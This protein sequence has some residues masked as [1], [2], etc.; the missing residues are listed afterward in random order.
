[1]FEGLCPTVLRNPLH[2]R[3]RSMKKMRALQ[4][5][6]TETYGAFRKPPGTAALDNAAARMFISQPPAGQLNTRPS[7]I[8]PH[9]RCPDIFSGDQS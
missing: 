1:M 6:H 8:S 5:R 7:A 3:Q 4:Y 9:L 2:L